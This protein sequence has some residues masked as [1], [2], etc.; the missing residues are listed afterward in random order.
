MAAVNPAMPKNTVAIPTGG[1]G[2]GVS[3]SV[4]RVLRRRYSSPL[5]G[6]AAPWAA[7]GSVRDG[8]DATTGAA[9]SGR[10]KGDQ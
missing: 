2:G 6:R 9:A 4:K 8:R 5:I 7:Y 1:G 10:R 3:R